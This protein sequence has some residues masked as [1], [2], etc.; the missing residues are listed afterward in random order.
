MTKEVKKQEIKHV[1]A[2]NAKPLEQF[3]KK[4]HNEPHKKDVFE[5]RFADNSKYIPIGVVET[6]LDELFFGLWQT[7]N[8]TWQIVANEIVGRI[9]LGVFHPVAKTWIWRD[10]AGAVLIQQRKGSAIDDIKA[11]IKNTLVKDFP[12]LKA[13]CLKNAAISLGPT[14]GRNLNR[15]YWFEFQP[16]TEQHEIGEQAAEE[17]AKCGSN[18]ELNKLLSVNREWLHND[19][20]YNQVIRKRKE[21]AHANGKK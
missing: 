14:F 11:K 5:N 2:F 21:L 17:I 8:F 12:H 4:L 13:Q 6:K 19:D 1:P 3:N 20:V 7:R 9:E 16:A 15:D 10:G 18:E